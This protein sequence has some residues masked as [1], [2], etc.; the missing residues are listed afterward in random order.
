MTRQAHLSQEKGKVCVVQCSRVSR[1]CS[2]RNGDTSL[3]VKER[4]L[5]FLPLDVFGS[6]LSL[7]VCV[8]AAIVS[9]LLAVGQSALCRLCLPHQV[10]HNCQ[11]ACMNGGRGLGAQLTAACWGCRVSQ[12]LQQILC[13]SSRMPLVGFCRIDNLENIEHNYFSTTTRLT[14]LAVRSVVNA[15]VD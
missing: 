1:S 4:L 9:V 7:P 12:L 15:T 2:C 10:P 14:K 11:A 13:V 5:P 6:C 8:S 3:S